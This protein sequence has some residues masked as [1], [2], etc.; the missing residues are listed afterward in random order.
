MPS[1]SEFAGTLG[2]SPADVQGLRCYSAAEAWARKELGRAAGSALTDL[3]GDNAAALYAYA[4]DLLKLPKAA[5]G[6]F[7]PDDL[8][9]MQAVA[10]DIGRRWAGQL[11]FGHRTGVSFA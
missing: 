7:G 3:E 2:L 1:H 6:M 10:G 5:F 8:E 9:G 4:A 11:K